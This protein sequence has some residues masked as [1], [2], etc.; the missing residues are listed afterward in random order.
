MSR[1]LYTKDYENTHSTSFAFP[2]LHFNA[3]LQISFKNKVDYVIS[4]RKRANYLGKL[5]I[6][7]L[8]K[9]IWSPWLVWFKC[10]TTA[11][12][13]STISCK[14]RVKSNFPLATFN[15]ANPEMDAVNSWFF[16]CKK[17]LEF[18]FPLLERECINSNKFDNQILIFPF[19]IL[20]WDD[21]TIFLMTQYY[22]FLFYRVLE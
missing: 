3:A 6:T 19:F 22:A 20:C 18:I 8:S 2:G 9:D 15:L 16:M 7:L 5:V 14:H 10:S 12:C 1:N 11:Y 13:G 4:F 17:L 21:S